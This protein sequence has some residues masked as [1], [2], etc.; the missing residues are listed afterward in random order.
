[1]SCAICALSDNQKNKTEELIRSGRSYASIAGELSDLGFNISTA[2]VMKHRAKH[3]SE[4]QSRDVDSP[5]KSANAYP[6]L[7]KVDFEQMYE[8]FRA[9]AESCPS[10]IKQAEKTQAVLQIALEDIV[11]QQTMLIADRINQHSQG[12]GPYPHDQMK[13]LTRTC[14]LLNSLPAYKNASIQEKVT[15]YLVKG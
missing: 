9:R 7:S 4:N 3:M 6:H 14:S 12:I 15:P 2:T 8:A 11:C 10:L 1:M 13:S 5:L